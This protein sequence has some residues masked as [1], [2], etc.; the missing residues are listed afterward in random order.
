M[1]TCCAP[2]C[3]NRRDQDKTKVFYR[4]PKDPERREKWTSAIKRVGSVGKKTKRWNPPPLN[5]FRLCSDHFISGRKSED[6]LSPDFVPSVFKHRRQAAKKHRL[7]QETTAPLGSNTPD[8]TTKPATKDTGQQTKK[9]I[10]PTCASIKKHIGLLKLEVQVLRAE[11]KLHQEKMCK[12]FKIESALQNSDKHVLLFTGLPTCSALKALFKVVSSHLKSKSTLTSFQQFAMTLI[13]LR[14]DLSFHVLSLYFGVNPAK[15]SGIFE[16]TINVMYCRLVPGLV[17]WPERSMLRQT[18]PDLFRNN[19]FERTLCIIDCFEIHIEKRSDLSASAQ[20]Y[21][22][23]KSANTMKYLLAVSPH[24]SV[25]FISNGWPGHTSNTFVMDNSDFLFLVR[26]GDLILADKGFKY[27]KSVQGSR[28]ITAF[29]R[30]ARKLCSLDVGS[31]C[32][33][34]I[35]MHI[36]SIIRVVQNKFIFLK[37]TMPVQFTVREHTEEVTLLDKIVKICCALSNV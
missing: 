17:V 9:N 8:H 25:T 33:L 20:C 26:P 37:S 10:E 3:W 24:G 4:I 22:T 31:I 36:E 1:D 23:Y 15:V 30:G 11:N 2:Q 5:G 7:E 35:L 18:L 6:P 28:K 16:H 32:S 29:I 19:Y 27:K 13:K 14:T 12:M 21:S 34:E